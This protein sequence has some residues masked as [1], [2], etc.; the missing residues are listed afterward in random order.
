MIK[1]KKEP[2]WNRFGDSRE[3]ND[4]RKVVPVRTRI[5]V[6]NTPM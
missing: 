4:K 6:K 2:A 1:A 3:R 5:P